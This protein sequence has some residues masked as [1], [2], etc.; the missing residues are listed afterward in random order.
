M[1][2]VW[3][4]RRMGVCLATSRN[5]HEQ[6]WFHLN[7]RVETEILNQAYYARFF[8]GLQATPIRRH[9]H[10]L[11]KTGKAGTLYL[12]LISRGHHHPESRFPAEHA[13]VRLWGL[14]DWVDF[15][16]CPHARENAERERILGID[17]HS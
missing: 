9:A 11:F 2:V 1:G 6:F 14:I 15:V 10:T 13:L 17:R 4:C 3:A 7:P 8:A 5:T 12:L 16:H